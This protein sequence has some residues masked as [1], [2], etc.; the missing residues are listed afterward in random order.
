MA[1]QLSGKTFAYIKCIFF[2]RC[3]KILLHYSSCTKLYIASSFLVVACEQPQLQLGVNTLLVTALSTF[4]LLILSLRVTIM[5]NMS[6]KVKVRMIVKW[7]IIVMNHGLHHG[8]ECNTRFGFPQ[9]FSNKWRSHCQRGFSI[10]FPTFFTSFC[11]SPFYYKTEQMKTFFML[12]LDRM[13]DLCVS[14]FFD[15][16]GGD[17]IQTVR[18]IVS[19][20]CLISHKE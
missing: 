9:Q 5:M 13:Y 3:F 12:L 17:D 15:G 19:L 1:L 18:H 7:N 16:C 2:I 20:V 4:H 11:S 14:P 6:V 8:T 10:P